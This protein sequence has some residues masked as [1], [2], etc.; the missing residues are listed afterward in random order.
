MT[1][2]FNREERKDLPQ[3]AQ[4]K[5]NWGATLDSENPPDEMRQEN[6]QQQTPDAADPDK[7]IHCQFW[8]IDLFLIH[9]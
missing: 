7:E 3:R 1:R 2:D 4:R 9:G 5:S 6:Q 8:G